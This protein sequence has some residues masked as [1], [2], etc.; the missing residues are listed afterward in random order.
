MEKGTLFVIFTVFYFILLTEI[1]ARSPDEEPVRYDGAQIWSVNL[2]DNQTT[3]IIF[4]LMENFGS[5]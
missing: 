1:G 3:Q 2:S 4:D 5:Y